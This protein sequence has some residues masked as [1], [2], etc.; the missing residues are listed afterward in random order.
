[1]LYHVSM[2]FMSNK[3]IAIATLGSWVLILVISL[4]NTM[5]YGSPPA[6]SILPQLLAAFIGWFAF[7]V[8]ILAVIKLY[9]SPENG[10]GMM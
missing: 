4:I 1:M 7:I 5:L 2:K 10:G 6:D 8:T 9:Q 3:T